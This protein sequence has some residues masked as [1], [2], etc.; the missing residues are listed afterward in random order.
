M[1]A[2]QT[3]DAAS[4]AGRAQRQRRLEPN[5]IIFTALMVVFAATIVYQATGLRPGVGRMPLFIGIPTLAGL[6]YLILR[7]MVI[8]EQVEADG[9][10]G[11]DGSIVGASVAKAASK[12]RMDLDKHSSPEVDAREKKRQAVFAIWAFGVFGLA[13]LTSFRI[14]VPL[15]LFAILLYAG[16]HWVKTTLITVITS[17]FLYILFIEILGVRL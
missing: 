3:G 9:E 1:S 11:P 14:A 10:E 7:E 2:D 12:A 5:R 8:G 13:M 17:A 6:A 15:G 16:V 4:T